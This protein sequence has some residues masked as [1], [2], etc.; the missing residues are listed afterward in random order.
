MEVRLRKAIAK[1]LARER[2]C[3]VATIGEGGAPHV[4]PVCHVL[5]DGKVYFATGGDS[6]KAKNLKA[7][8]R[9]TVLVDLYAEEWSFLKGAMMHGT[10]RFIRRGPEFR[11]IR[12]LLYQKYPQY[13]EDAALAEA[14]DVI[15]EMTPTRLASWSIDA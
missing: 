1:F 13:P 3:R 10:A 15:V 6:Q 11:K 4:V 5:L 12:A 8:P 14:D 2:V 7:N 9:M